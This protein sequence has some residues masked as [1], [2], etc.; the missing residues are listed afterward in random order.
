ME[1]FAE[2]FDNHCELLP[3]IAVGSIE[4]DTCAEDHGVAVTVSWL[5]WAAG[6]AF[7]RHETE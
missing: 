6:V 5:F 2:Q 1:F 4:C 7:F 3:G